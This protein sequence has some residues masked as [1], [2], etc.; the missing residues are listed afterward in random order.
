M[1][2]Q[3]VI[4]LEIHIEL[5]TK[6]KMF[7]SCSASY[8]N[9]KPNTHTCPICLGLPGAMP[10]ANILAIKYT[11]KLG[12]ALGCS[13]PLSSKFDRKNYFY[14]DLSKGFQISQYK[15]PF[16]SNGKVKV[17]SKFININRAHLE[18]DTGKLI[19]TKVNNKNITL[20]DF[21]RS[22]VPLVEIVTNPDISTSQ[23]A[24][25]YAQQIQQIARYLQISAADMDEGSM[26][27]EP[28]VSLRKAGYKNLPNYKVELKNINS[29][30]FV[31]NAIN[32]EIERQSKILDSGNEP[33]TETRGWNERKNETISQRKKEM[34]HDYRYF[35]EPDLPPFEFSKSVISSLKKNLPELPQEKKERF[36]K[37]YEL[38]EEDINSLTQTRYMADFFEKTSS[39]YKKN[40][41]KVANWI[42]GELIN[43]L[44]KQ[45]KTLNETKL[46]P[47]ALAQLLYFIDTKKITQ[48]NAKEI[49]TEIVNTG[50]MPSQ[51]INNLRV[52]PITNVEYEQIVDKIIKNNPH[53]VS[54]YKKGKKNSIGFLIGQIQKETKGRA[55]IELIKKMLANKLD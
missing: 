8:F 34:A 6:S 37:V 46:L 16:A 23:E 50:V 24:K 20:I 5:A 13:I 48:T 42:T 7:C 18:E 2:Y 52:K 19:H 41:Q 35:P 27:I 28:N 17:E 4:G 44:N 54:D 11:Q 9:A 39:D 40:P 12:I 21:N 53:A 38:K 26:R 43:I 51:I 45:S 25:S 14:P 30:K 47:A 55:D 36:A 32:Y 1:K 10:K 3:P 31:Q 15:L 22:G 33:E 29:F 49:L